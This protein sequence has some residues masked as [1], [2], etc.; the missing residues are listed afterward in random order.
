MGEL[1][2]AGNEPDRQK[3]ERL[4]L[5]DVHKA[6]APAGTI[7]NAAYQPA[8]DPPWH[9]RQELLLTR[10]GAAGDQLHGPADCGWNSSSVQGPGG[11][12]VKSRG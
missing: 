6:P 9:P 1:S 7:N 11:W 3:P 5:T 8:S 4:C 2:K 12:L 10:V